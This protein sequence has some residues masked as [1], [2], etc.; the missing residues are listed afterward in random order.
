MWLCYCFSRS[1]AVEAGT[2]RF[3]IEALLDPDLMA[4]G[5]LKYVWKNMVT[6]GSE[7]GASNLLNSFADIL[8][9]GDQS[10]W[11][12]NVEYYLSQGYS[13]E[14]AFEYALGDQ[15]LG[16]GLDVLG[17]MLSGGFLSGGYGAVNFASS[18]GDSRI[19][20]DDTAVGNVRPTS[21]SNMIQELTATAHTPLERRALS[22]YKNAVELLEN[23]QRVLAD[24]Q[25][26]LQQ[27]AATGDVHSA[28]YNKLK[29]AELS[30]NRK[31]DDAQRKVDRLEN[32]A[33]VK[34]LKEK[35]E[36]SRLANANQRGIINDTSSKY[37]AYTDKNDPY[38][39]KRDAA[40]KAY[41]EQVRNRKRE[42][43]IAAVA[44]NSGFSETDIDIVFAHIFELEHR[45]ADG[46]VHRFDSDYYIQ[47]S[48]MRLRSGRGVQ[49]H[50]ITLL[51]H[52][53]MEANI[54][55]KGLDV[56]YE[57][58]HREAEKLYNYR[59]DLHK[60]LKDRERKEK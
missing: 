34:G 14:R 28:E 2:E 59:D 17:G 4:D 8:I 30:L 53:L 5:F 42:Y 47:Q 20:R 40:A 9:S 22:Q 3:S 31:V 10:Q 51:N 18:R 56:A 25:N 46:E 44:K 32:S 57:D 6:E 15:A 52:E 38:Q 54:M 39:E 12:Q 24:T 11:S 58:A 23:R 36:N 43:E 26:R 55:G 16:L 49:K 48:W 1:G 19:A 7:E 27:L 60:Y 45:F 21:Q 35:A 33:S 29:S 50:D 37:G 13:D 41:Y